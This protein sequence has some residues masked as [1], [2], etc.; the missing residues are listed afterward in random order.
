MNAKNSCGKRECSRPDGH[1]GLMQILPSPLPL[2]LSRDEGI[3][4]TERGWRA[5]TL[6]RLARGVY[7]ET[8]RWGPLPP[9]EKYLVRVHAVVAITPRRIIC[10]ESAAALL[11]VLIAYPSRPVHTLTPEGSAREYRGVRTH[12]FAEAREIIIVDGI[13]LTSPAA[14][15]VDIARSRP[16][17]EGLAYA[18][19]LLRLD[20]TITPV[21]LVGLNEAMVSGRGRRHA[22]WALDRSSGT[23]ESVLES[24]S[25][26]LIEWL[27]YES[28]TLQQEFWF[29][30]H[31]DRADFYW[32]GAGI[33]G[34]ADG[35]VK[36]SVAMGDPTTAIVAE[37]RRE[38]RLRRNTSGLA[39]WGWPEIHEIEPVDAALRAAGLR[40]VRPRD[41]MRLASFHQLGRD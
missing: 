9:W 24:V 33:I 40:P 25:I 31:V 28:P 5:G 26:A 10:D 36:Y 37:K 22:R 13:R 32:K 34:E 16:F 30:G 41:T 19:A 20:S 27:G 4:H 23:P 35:D 29:E 3:S 6:T 12:V 1:R 39:R 17:A 21:S 2:L 18:D 14:T 15:A 8:N 38:N 11:G 7:V